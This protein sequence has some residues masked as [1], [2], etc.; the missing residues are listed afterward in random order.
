MNLKHLV[1]LLLLFVCVNLS[2]QTKEK[3]I[4]ISF[5]NIPLSEAMARIE[6]ASGYTFF[7]D[8]KQTDI[9][10]TVSLNAKKELISE[11]LKKMFSKTNLNFEVTSTQIALFPKKE[12]KQVGQ[13]INIQGKV[14]DETGEPIIGANVVEEGTTNGVITDLDGNYTLMA[15]AGANLKIS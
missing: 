11:A 1:F 5:S 4:T 8:A 9:K 12:V 7:Y 10:Q 15:P 14:V 6:K 2:A 3:Q 13:P